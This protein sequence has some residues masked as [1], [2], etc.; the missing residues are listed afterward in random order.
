MHP[1]LIYYRQVVLLLILFLLTL[2]SVSQ[3]SVFGQGV[4][5]PQPEIITGK[6]GLPQAF[7]PAIVQDRQGFIWMATRDG[8]CRYDGKNFKVFQ[9]TTDGSPGISSASLSGLSLDKQGRL[10]IFS[11]LNDIDILDPL[12]EKFINFSREP[13]FKSQLGQEVIQTHYFDQKGQL[14]L[15]FR[16]NKIACID[17][18]THHLRQYQRQS[19]YSDYSA[20]AQD[21]QGIIWLSNSNGLYRLDPLTDQFTKYPLPDNNIRGIALRSNGELFVLSNR[22]VLIL[23][24]HSGRIRSF[25]LPPIASLIPPWQNKCIVEDSKGNIYFSNQYNDLVQFSETTGINVLAKWPEKI[26]LRSLLVDRSDVLWIGTNKDGI[27]KYNLRADMFEA[28]PYQ[29]DFYTDLFVRELGIPESQ[30]PAEARKALPYYFR[31]TIDNDRKL[32]FNMGDRRFYKLDLQT[33]QV[34]PVD[35]P[36][37]IRSRRTWDK[38]IAPMAT[39]P[40]GQV[41]IITDSLAMWHENGRWQPFQYPLRAKSRLHTAPHTT[42]EGEI[43][44][45]VVDQHALWLI[46]D[47]KGLYRVDR[48]N[49]QVTSYMHDSKNPT[50]LSSNQLF[51]LFGDPLD[52][53]ILWVGTFGSGLCRFDKRTGACRRFSTQTGLP[54]NVIY[55]AIPDQQGF[56]WIG[57]N[58][59]LCRMDRRSFKTSTYTH[60]DGLLEDEFNRFHFLHLPNDRIL[61]GGLDGITSFYPRQLKDDTYQPPI[62]ITDIQL[63]NQSI[64]PGSLTGSLPVQAISYLDLPYNQNFITIRYATLQYNRQAKTR[65]RYQLV[66]LNQQW[67]ESTEPIVQYTDLRWGSY[68]LKLNASNTSGIWSNHIRVMNLVIRP[69]WWATWWAILL[70][71]VGMLVVGYLLVRSYLHQQETKQLKEVDAMKVRFFTNIAHEFRTPLTLILGPVETLKKRLHSNEDQHQ[72]NLINENAAQIL[73]LVNQLIDLS[74]AEA[75]VLRLNESLGDLKLFIKKLVSSFDYQAKAKSIQLIFQAGTLDTQYWF[76]SEKLER[77]ITN[78]VIHALKFSPVGG[79]VSVDLR[80]ST[81]LPTKSVGK[82]PTHDSWIQLTISDNGTGI[83]QEELPRIFDRFYQGENSQPIEQESLG[84]RLALVKELVEIQSGTILVTSK[85]SLGT[86]FT[87]YLPYRPATSIPASQPSI[88]VEPVTKPVVTPMGSQVE[89]RSDKTSLILLIEDNEILREFIFENLSASYTIHQAKNG[90]EGW[91]QAIKQVPDLVISDVMMPIMDGF[92]LCRKLKEDVR[93]SHIPVVLLTAKASVDDRLEGLSLGAD[94]YIAKPFHIQELQLRIRNLLEQRR[95]LQQWVLASITSADP[96]VHAPAPTD[97]LIEK[98]CQIIEDHLDEATFGAEELTAASGMSRMNLHRKLRALADTS[99]GEF[100]RNYR[101]KRAAQ[102]LRQ[103]HSVSETAYLV[104]F[105]DPSYFARSFRK[106]YQMAP[107][108]FSR[109]N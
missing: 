103:G 100:I 8:L 25:L 19:S 44:Q 33:K 3:L 41:W 68:T 72:L 5:L 90:L 85:A 81:H 17:P 107:S 53:A 77:I 76:D 42:I 34:T 80:V 12:G 58:Q 45:A 36:A 55:S 79:K 21:K 82:Y 91:E 16:S 65:Y 51:C 71:L 104:G 87:I 47:T 48:V 28:V 14:W 49:G 63:N 108:T 7:V 13:F 66:G 43:L 98:L 20:F 4:A 95:Q 89:K 60:E 29:H 46:T 97:P 84:V 15:S 23:N 96:P 61:M 101:L 1:V 86:T 73:E 24:P 88:V 31:Y 74:K 92:T 11:D 94:D 99:T 70:Y 50:S 18:V 6:Q 57:T 56:L 69:P 10:W 54:N 26:A 22:S 52:P 40:T 83:R 27:R 64:V 9:P 38:P 93:T 105:E 59:G 39:D 109:N 106:V 32:W 30:I 78:L 2:I 35:V 75:N 102:L 37:T 62:Q 67:V